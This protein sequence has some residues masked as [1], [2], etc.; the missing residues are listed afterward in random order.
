MGAGIGFPNLGRVF[1]PSPL[2]LMMFL[3][4]LS[5]LKIEFAEVLKNLEKT[6]SILIVLS[7]LKLLVIP[8]GLFFLTQAIW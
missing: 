3:L 8:A 5:F 7:L 4:F 1:L 2:Y 6:T